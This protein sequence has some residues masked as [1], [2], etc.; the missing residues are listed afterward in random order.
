MNPRNLSIVAACV[1]LTACG[2]LKDGALGRF[3]KYDA[4]E[5]ALAVGILV[6]TRELEKNCSNLATALSAVG[7]MSTKTDLFVTY[8]EGRPHNKRTLTM[9]QDLRA[10]I[11]DTEDK[12]TVSEFFCR[13][14]AKN[15]VKA[16]ELLRTSSGE[17]PE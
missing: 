8:L 15:M 11:R 5:Y 4:N 14:R 16:A 7:E 6:S 2:S 9:A 17:K 3:H 10:M 12:T 13:E 1:A